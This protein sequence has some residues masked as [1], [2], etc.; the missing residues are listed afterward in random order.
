MSTYKFFFE[1]GKPVYTVEFDTGWNEEN[2]CGGYGFNTFHPVPNNDQ[3]VMKISVMG[4]Q[5]RDTL[6]IHWLKDKVSLVLPPGPSFTV[7]KK[8]SDE[9]VVECSVLRVTTV[10]R[11]GSW[12]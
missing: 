3:I 6:W 11:V 7:T 8:T 5:Q 9:L 4:S 1:D 12:S 2:Q 10:L